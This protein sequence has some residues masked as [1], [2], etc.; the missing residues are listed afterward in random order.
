MVNEYPTQ[1]KPVLQDSRCKT[2]LE[3]S[4]KKNKLKENVT[5]RNS[6]L[7]LHIKIL[8]NKSILRPIWTYVYK[9][10]ERLYNDTKTSI[11]RNCRCFLLHQKQKPPSGI[12]NGH[13][14]S[15][16]HKMSQK[17]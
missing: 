4:R 10:I 8:L 2:A 14:G 5:G 11:K 17:S 3:A 6:T 9:A 7:P 15:D 12:R 13:C 16:N 1:T